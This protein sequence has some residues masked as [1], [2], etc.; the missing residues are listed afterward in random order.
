[1]ERSSPAVL[2]A[3]E[4]GLGRNLVPGEE[5]CWR[6]RA[7][8]PCARLVPWAQPRSTVEASLP[9]GPGP[10]GLAVPQGLW[11]WL[12]LPQPSSSAGCDV[13][14]SAP[15]ATRGWLSCLVHS[16][17]SWPTD[18]SGRAGRPRG[19][20]FGVQL[21]WVQPS[22]KQW[23]PGVAGGLRTG[24]RLWAGSSRCGTTAQK[25]LQGGAEESSI[26]W[27]VTV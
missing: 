12:L 21:L 25:K 24:P 11:P 13:P 6:S 27:A 23:L 16:R 2:L 10:A 9:A 8:L 7:A 15:A 5:P 20:V 22:L 19:S 17:D 14:E 1:M 26:F 4:K 18:R 3:Q